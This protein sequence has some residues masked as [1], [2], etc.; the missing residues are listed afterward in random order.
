MTDEDTENWF[1]QDKSDFGYHTWSE[2]STVEEVITAETKHNKRTEKPTEI[3][4]HGFISTKSFHTTIPVM[5]H[6]FSNII[7]TFMHWQNL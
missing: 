2:T 6:T 3:K 1:Q 7:P 5:T 4:K